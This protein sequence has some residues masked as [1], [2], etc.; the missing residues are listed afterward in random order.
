MDLFIDFG[1]G[2]ACASA[3]ENNKSEENIREQV[4]HLKAACHFLQITAPIITAVSSRQEE[5]WDGSSNRL[6]RKVLPSEESSLFY[7]IFHDKFS[8]RSL[9][10]LV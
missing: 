5:L 2:R 3:N 9:M 4:C 6:M 10:S 8:L 1:R 7:E